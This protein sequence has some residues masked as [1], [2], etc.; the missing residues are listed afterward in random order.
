MSATASNSLD[1]VKV[2]TSSATLA[3]G[4]AVYLSDLTRQNLLRAAKVRFPDTNGKAWFSV[5]SADILSAIRN[6]DVPAIVN[7]GGAPLT[8]PATEKQLSYLA[9]LDP[10]GSYSGL[11]KQQASEAIERL[12]ADKAAQAPATPPA[13]TPAPSTPAVTPV[14]VSGT[15][16]D[17]LRQALELLAAGMTPAQ[18]TAALDVEAVQ[19]LI[20]ATVASIPPTVVEVKL[21]NRETITVEGRTHKV[22]P[23]VVKYVARGY[24]VLLVGPAGSGKSTIGAQVFK[25]LSHV[26]SIPS[27]S[28]GP[29]TPT[30]KVF[31]YNDANG[32]NVST[33]FQ[34]A[35][36]GT[37]ENPD[38]TPF[39]G[40]ELDNGHPGLVC[41]LNQALSNDSAAFAAG[42]LPKGSSFAFIGTANTYGRGGDRQYVGRNQLDAATLD[43]FKVVHV[44]Y[45]EDLE[46]DLAMSRVERDEDRPKAEAFI[47]KVRQHRANVERHGLPVIVSPRSVI[48][49]VDIVCNLDIPEAEALEDLY[50]GGLSDDLRA[51]VTG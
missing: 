48:D 9:K 38:G 3:D 22:F 46:Y 1:I 31:G 7:E 19:A 35:F 34:G 18:Q 39:L 20:D 25:A 29:T 40:D 28:Y 2:D 33:P 43:R 50:L 30:S 32:N 5:K 23:K 4:S 49:G 10:S 41:E 36:A 8:G 47:R 45:D 11:T 17:L 42:Q 21:P 14:A 51:K 24:N 44:D 26:G 12:K 27:M 16:E 37:P 6:G 15:P 13:Q